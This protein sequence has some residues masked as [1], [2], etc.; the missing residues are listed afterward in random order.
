MDRPQPQQTNEQVPPP[1]AERR[2]KPYAPPVLTFYGAVRDLTMG[3]GSYVNDSGPNSKKPNSDPRLKQS[4][5]RVGTHPLG[6]GLYVFEYR[7]AAAI[8]CAPGVHFGVMAD[9]V[10]AL[11]PAAV[12]T[13]ADGYL[14]VDYAMLGIT[15]ANS[16]H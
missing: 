6:F 3:N 14:R 2:K 11:L 5:R 12:E 7:D 16:V 15:D 8:G 9:E 4:V 1:A 13:G 10:Q